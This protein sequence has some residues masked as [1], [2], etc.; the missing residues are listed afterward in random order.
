METT[1]ATTTTAITTLSKNE[2]VLV[3]AKSSE[4]W[5]Q[6]MLI[7]NKGL[8]IFKN[9]FIV[10]IKVTILRFHFNSELEPIYMHPVRL[11]IKI[12]FMFLEEVTK[13]DR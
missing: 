8:N 13:K 5:K 1:T 10:L 11:N 3:L 2:M 12:N 4:T 9:Y 7:N 6:P